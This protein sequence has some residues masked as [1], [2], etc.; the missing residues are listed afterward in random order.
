VVALVAPHILAPDGVAALKADLNE[1]RTLRNAMAHKPFW[2]HPELNEEG[3]VVNLV[4][5]ITR[6]KAPLPLST[7]LI[8]K[9][10]AQIGG[11]IEKTATLAAAAQLSNSRVG[12]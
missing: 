3:R 1:L 11:L 7:A 9:V 4:P 10:N 5:M 2:F 6:G 12:D 8:E